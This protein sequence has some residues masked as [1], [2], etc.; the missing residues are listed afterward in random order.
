MAKKTFDNARKNRIKQDYQWLKSQ[1]RI[2]MWNTIILTLFALSTLFM[3]W[4]CWQVFYAKT[5][6]SVKRIL[7]QQKLVI[8]ISSAVNVVSSIMFTSYTL[9]NS[10]PLSFD[11]FAVSFN[12][13]FSLLVLAWSILLNTGKSEVCVQMAVQNINTILLLYMTQVFIILNFIVNKWYW[14]RIDQRDIKKRQLD[15]YI[16]K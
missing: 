9:R 5:E 10:F 14:I 3:V 11:Q 2:M 16:N 15:L 13:A 8:L 4:K 1:K 6:T 12:L 7:S